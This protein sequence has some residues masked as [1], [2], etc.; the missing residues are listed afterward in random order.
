MKLSF[1]SF[2]IFTSLFSLSPTPQK[3]S[4]QTVIRNSSNQLLANQQV[5]IKISVL[6]GIE[7]GIVVYSER[8]TPSTNANGLATLYIGTGN[9]LSGNFQNINW[10]SGSFAE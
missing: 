3:F 7:T 4:Y 1:L 5:G 6:Q 8:H 2:F 10:A 9:V